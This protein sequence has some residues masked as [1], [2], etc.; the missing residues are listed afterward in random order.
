[1]TSLFWTTRQTRDKG[2]F[3]EGFYSQLH[4]V[5]YK[6]NCVY[7]Q[8]ITLVIQTLGGKDAVLVAGCVEVSLLDVH[9]VISFVVGDSEEI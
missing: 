4:S 3:L 5:P 6:R 9:V 2:R 1:M 7:A 8:Y